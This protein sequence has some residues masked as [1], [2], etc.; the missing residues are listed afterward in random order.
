MLEGKF[1][2]R[3]DSKPNELG[4]QMI[5]IMYC[6]QGVP[7]KKKTGIS[8]KP[9]HWLGDSVSGKYIKGGPNGNPKASILN[10]RLVNI[11]KGYDKIIDSLLL[12][13]NQ[14]IS[15]PVLRSILNGTYTEKLEKEKGKVDFVQFV[16]EYNEEL[17]KLGKVGY[18]VWVN[19]QSYMKKFKE[20]L[21]KTKH[22]HT[23]SENLLYCRDISVD[24]IK[25]YILWRKDNGNTNDTINFRKYKQT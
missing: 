2:L 9:E 17:Y 13:K 1:F 14:V 19:V 23:T 3:S 11:K 7:C 8:V 5:H 12:E 6:T 21:Q 16:L 20:F 24:L 4:E 10:Q 15:V 18:S 25:D 22:I